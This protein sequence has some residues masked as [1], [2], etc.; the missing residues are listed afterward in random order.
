MKKYTFLI[1]AVFLLVNCTSQ[2]PAE[3][4]N[5][6][7]STPQLTRT[8]TPSATL[9]PHSIPSFTITPTPTSFQII[10]PARTL[11][12]QESENALLELLRTNGNCT[13]KCI[14]GIRPDE[15]T[16]QEAINVMSLWGTI[17][18]HRNNLG[19]TYILLESEPLNGKVGVNL[20]IGTWTN[21]FI[22]IDRVG[23]G[24]QNIGG[25]VETDLWEENRNNWNGVRLDNLLKAYGV[26]SYV[27]YD[28]Y[29]IFAG[30]LSEGRTIGYIMEIQYKEMQLIINSQAIAYYDGKNIF[31]C[32]TKDPQF[33]RMEIYPESSLNKRQ[34]ATPVEWQLLSGV[35]LEA[36][37]QSYTDDANPDACIITNIEQI[38]LLQPSFN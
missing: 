13:G 31:L 20:S 29:R 14:A 37:Y 12:P 32:P 36:F 16:V 4:F 26:P 30:S 10:L 3:T 11:S 7:T 25:R 22:T 17:R 21:K 24:I 34:G 18:I 6:A 2:A 19:N 35:N 38:E 5:A 33:L 27:G 1:L 23:F 8:L 9:Q 15:M 28:F